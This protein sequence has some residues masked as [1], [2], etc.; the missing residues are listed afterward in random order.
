ML[1]NKCNFLIISYDFNDVEVKFADTKVISF[2]ET[3][4]TGI[5]SCQY[6]NLAAY[7]L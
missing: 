1:V 5:K 7:V 3:K 6:L 4:I 2:L